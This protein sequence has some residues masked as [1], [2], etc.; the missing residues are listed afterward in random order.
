MKER[1][2]LRGIVAAGTAVA[3]LAFARE[4]AP[5]S[6]KIDAS[7]RKGPDP[8]AASVWNQQ[9]QPVPCGDLGEPNCWN[10]NG[11]EVGF[12]EAMCNARPGLVAENGVCV[13]PTTTTALPMEAAAV[14]D[15][16][17]SGPEIGSEPTEKPT[18]VTTTV[19]RRSY[20]STPADIAPRSVQEEVARSTQPQS[21]P[22]PQPEPQAIPVEPEPKAAPKS[23]TVLDVNGDPIVTKWPVITSDSNCGK[24]YEKPCYDREAGSYLGYSPA[25]CHEGQPVGDK[26]LPAVE[27]PANRWDQVVPTGDATFDK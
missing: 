4:S 5:T 1:G 2:R 8:V 7:S 10:P 18:H 24:L 16:A 20:V 11:S 17:P 22:Q 27:N 9:L 19:A 3:A 21:E 13:F 25:N 12:Y 23:G 26:C 14:P 6:K 15:V